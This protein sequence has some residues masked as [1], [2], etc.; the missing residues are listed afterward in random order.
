LFQLRSL[1]SLQWNPEQITSQLLISHNTIYQKIYADN[2]MGGHLW[3]ALRCQKKDANATL[4]AAIDG[5][6]LR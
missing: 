3:I 1:L 2:A 5:S 4:L 6:N